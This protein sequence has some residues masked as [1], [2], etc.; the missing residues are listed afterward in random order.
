MD[1]VI[2]NNRQKDIKLGRAKFWRI[3]FFVYLLVFSLS[4]FNNFSCAEVG[5]LVC[6]TNGWLQVYAF[7]MQL[8]LFSHY[9]SGLYFDGRRWVSI[10]AFAVILVPISMLLSLIFLRNGWLKLFFAYVVLSICFSLL[11]WLVV[12]ML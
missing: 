5:F 10:I 6:R 11:L 3:F 7:P 4:I 12:E 8:D 2:D 9:F 1:G